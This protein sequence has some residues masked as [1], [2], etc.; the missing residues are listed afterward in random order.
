MLATRLFTLAIIVAT[1]LAACTATTTA[2]PA[3]MVP[4]TDYRMVAGQ[5]E[6]LVSGLATRRA[7]VSDAVR[8]T[9]AEDGTYD[10][11]IYREIGAFEGKGRF[12]LRDGK[13][14]TQQ[15][16]RP[17]IL[18]LYE[19]DGRRRLKGEGVSRNGLPVSVDLKPV[20]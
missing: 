14:V 13:L 1:A 3:T 10:F 4:I 6:G 5:W 18:T 12:S 9:I 17:T 8:V 7:D 16:P 2:P 19:Q 15:E 20:R 11:G